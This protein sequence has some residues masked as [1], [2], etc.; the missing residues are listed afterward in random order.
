MNIQDATLIVLTEAA[1]CP[2]LAALVQPTY[3]DL[4]SGF[5]VSHEVLS[6]IIGKA[7]E[8]GVL[9]SMHSKYSAVAY[10]AILMPILMEVDRQRPVPPRRGPASPDGIDPLTAPIGTF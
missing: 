2:G 8:K 10:D 7:S 5:E 1:A 3:D 6:G 9:R 4:A